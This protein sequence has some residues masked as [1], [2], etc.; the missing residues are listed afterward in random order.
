MRVYNNQK[1]DKI[2]YILYRCIRAILYFIQKGCFYMSEFN[3]KDPIVTKKK[4]LRRF[5][6]N[7]N[8]VHIK[9]RKKDG[10]IRVMRATAKDIPKAVIDA[11]KGTHPSNVDDDSPYVNVWDLD[12]KG[13]RKV[14]VTT[15]I[16]IY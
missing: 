15:L 10:S 3:E 1:T 11:I 12:A 13:W 2:D 14:N 6:E 9:F 8:L 5:L 4:L 7:S 16:D